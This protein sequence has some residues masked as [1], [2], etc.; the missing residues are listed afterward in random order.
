MWEQLQFQYWTHVRITFCIAQALLHR[1]AYMIWFLLIIASNVACVHNISYTLRTCITFT[2]AP[3]W[4]CWPHIRAR[5]RHHNA[6]LN[7]RT[8]R[9][10]PM[11]M[12]GHPNMSWAQG[13]HMT[14]NRG[15]IEHWIRNDMYSRDSNG[16]NR[17]K[18]ASILKFWSMN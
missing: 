5:H 14:R 18:R 7:I 1:Y 4:T 6:H 2:F 15:H 3:T 11:A 12:E 16:G 13:T 9:T 17:R 8:S 10:T